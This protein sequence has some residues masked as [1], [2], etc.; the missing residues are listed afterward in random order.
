M[1]PPGRKHG[2]YLV[3]NSVKKDSLYAKGC[4]QLE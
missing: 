3:K 1:A 2:D 4:H